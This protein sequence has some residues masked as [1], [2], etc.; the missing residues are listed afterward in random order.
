MEQHIPHPHSA[1]ERDATL[2]EVGDMEEWA[3]DSLTTMPVKDFSFSTYRRLAEYQYGRINL[4]SYDP[5]DTARAYLG[6]H[7]PKNRPRDRR[8]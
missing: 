4:I 6:V 5:S 1:F 2:M 7:A 8:P 3:D